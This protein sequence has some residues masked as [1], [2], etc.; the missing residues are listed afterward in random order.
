MQRMTVHRGKAAVG[1]GETAIPSLHVSFFHEQPFAKT[2]ATSVVRTKPPFAVAAATAA[3][4][5]EAATQLGAKQNYATYLNCV[6][7]SL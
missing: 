4:D 1:G 7:K 5:Q 3:F 2:R 6:H